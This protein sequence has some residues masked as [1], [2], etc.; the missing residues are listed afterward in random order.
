MLIPKERHLKLLTAE[1]REFTWQPGAAG[2]AILLAGCAHGKQTG[3]LCCFPSLYLMITQCLN[4]SH[5]KNPLFSQKLELLSV[6]TY[7]GLSFNL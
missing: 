5:L 7:F 4:E 1:H 6:G 2:V 3:L